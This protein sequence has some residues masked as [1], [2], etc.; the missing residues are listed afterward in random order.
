VGIKSWKERFV[1]FSEALSK[2]IPRR[3]ISNEK[4]AIGDREESDET[5]LTQRFFFH[6]AI[7]CAKY[8]MGQKYF[9]QDRV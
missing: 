8:L 2:C 3:S 1:L 7:N 6:N 4:Y 5:A 9:A